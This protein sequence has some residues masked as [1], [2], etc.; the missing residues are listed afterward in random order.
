MSAFTKKYQYY[1]GLF[2]MYDTISIDQSYRDRRT[3]NIFKT[4]III[5]NT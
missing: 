3:E 5:H 4:G 1:D 2:K